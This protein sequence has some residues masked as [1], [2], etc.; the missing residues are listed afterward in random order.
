MR[1][2]DQAAARLIA[3]LL[4]LLLATGLWGAPVVAGAQSPATVVTDSTI[5]RTMREARQL[6]GTY[7]E[8]RAEAILRDLLPQVEARY[9]P[10]AL[11]VADVL[12][13]LA[14]AA[15]LGGT[16]QVDDVRGWLQ[17]AIAIRDETPGATAMDRALA[18]HRQAIFLR[19]VG[20]VEPAAAA[21]RRGLEI[22][23]EAGHGHGATA[24][25]LLA[26]SALID[27]DRGEFAQ[28]EESLAKA[29]TIAASVDDRDSHLPLRL[30]DAWAG[31]RE[32]QGR[33]VEAITWRQ[34]ALALAEAIYGPDHNETTKRLK[35]LG[36]T[37]QRA[38]HLLEAADPL[39]RALANYEAA[40]GPSSTQVASAANGLGMLCMD[41]GDYEAA[42]RHLE[43]ALEITRTKG[44]P[45]NLAAALQNLGV[46]SWLMGDYETA[47]TRFEQAL[48]IHEEQYGPGHQYVADD[49]TNLGA[50]N[51]LA[52]DAEE[53]LRLLDRSIATTT[54]FGG[55]DHPI[56]GIAL[57]NRAEALVALGRDDEARADFARGIPLAEAGLGPQS[58]DIATMRDTYGAFLA[59]QGDFA[60]ARDELEA[61]Q[62]IRVAVL[63][64]GHGEVA[65]SRQNLANLLADE[66][67]LAEALPLLERA[68]LDL[69]QAYGPQNPRVAIALADL[70]TLRWRAGHL[71][72]A[73][74]PALRAEEI[75]REHLQLVARGLPERQALA[76]AAT[77]PAGLDLAVSAALA[78][79]RP[80]TVPLVWR[81]AAAA[82]AQVLDEMVARR[83]AAGIGQADQVAALA[84]AR[85]RLANLVVRGQ[86]GLSAEDYEAELRE[87]R[88]AKE[89]LERELAR[90]S[91]AFSRLVQPSFRDFADLAAALPAQAA[92]VSFQRYRYG[93]GEDRYA[94]FVLPHSLALPLLIDLGGAA[95]IDASVLAWRASVAGG[96]VPPGPLAASAEA[97][98]RAHGQRLRMAVWDP[99]GSLVADAARVYVVPDGALNLVNLAALPVGQS[100]YLVEQGPTLHRLATERDLLPGGPAATGTGGGLLIVSG[101]DYDRR[102]GTRFVAAEAGRTD[103]AIYRGKLPTCGDFADLHFVPLP[104][105]AAEGREVRELW[106]QAEMPGGA[107][108]LQGDEAGEDRFKREAAGHGMLH[109][110]TH[111]FF[112]DGSCDGAA[113]GGAENPLLRSGLA[114]AGANRRADAG[115]DVD[116]GVL[117]AEEIASLDL[118]G[119]VWAVLSGCDT[120]RGTPAVGEGLLGLQRAFQMAGA[121]TVISS[122]WPVRDQDA[123]LWMDELYRARLVDGLDTAE[124]VRRASRRTLEARR[125]DGSGGHPLAWAAFVATGDWR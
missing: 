26:T 106:R 71:D 11:P 119:V 123:Q 35:A 67:R 58:L 6:L 69:E 29:D 30:L 112:L 70:A 12:D 101:P 4:P 19:N 55:A 48:T 60:A 13:L 41:T 76:Y 20:E 49:L 33:L 113:G 91:A 51:L 39:Q 73:L 25:M 79:P 9:G 2:F 120:G 56:V 59:A 31:L 63:G 88:Q 97:D 82:R 64:E 8:P 37:L 40:F 125:A 45:T 1:R 46:L 85:L 111:G 116:D 87:T 84:A 27:T 74:A 99:V 108:L 105:A 72:Q 80:D 86:V 65:L 115:L 53:A 15:G 103:V 50:I 62:A 18:W 22:L 57:A 121:G 68:C 24:G 100:A 98:C 52:G 36:L 7:D 78:D 124:A 17:R 104:G 5:V 114:L 10:Q 44:I 54:T 14:E 23:D 118:D 102:S 90:D 43:L 16:G 122:L 32:G 42:Q 21:I 117:T 61:A 75:G 109:L 94:V 83:V 95:A 28:A 66:G 47:R 89:Q 3:R 93:D 38:G 96:A 77:R 34:Q 107:T 81:A 110:A 92:L